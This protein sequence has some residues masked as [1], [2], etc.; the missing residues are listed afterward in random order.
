MVEAHPRRLLVVPQPVALQA[1]DGIRV[2]LG[3]EHLLRG[4][5]VQDLVEELRALGPHLPFELDAARLPAPT[6]E[7]AAVVPGTSLVLAVDHVR[8]PERDLAITARDAPWILPPELLEERE[9]RA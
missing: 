8:R 6:C 9:Q 4:G 3:D 1:R 5:P 7:T 2:V